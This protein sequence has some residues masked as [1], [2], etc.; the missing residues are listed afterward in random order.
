[1]GRETV[2][3]TKRRETVESTKGRETVKLTVGR[4]TVKFTI[5]CETG[6]GQSRGAAGGGTPLCDFCPVGRG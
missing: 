4:E 1:M 3:L 5:G 2:N 6:E